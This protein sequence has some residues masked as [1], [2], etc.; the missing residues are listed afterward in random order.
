MIARLGDAMRLPLSAQNTLLTL[1]GFA[2][3]FSERAWDEA[4][5]APIRAA[6]AHTMKAH[7]PYPA[8]AL[9][10][11]WNI[12]QMNAPATQL[13][14]LMGLKEGDSLL[15]LLM[16]DMLPQMI[17]NWSEV[18]HHTALRLRTESSAQG[19]NAALDEV[20]AHLGKVPLAQAHRSDAVIPMILNTG[21][22]RL[23]MFAT[24]AQ[25]GTPEDVM[26]DAL[27]IELFFPS[28]D[29]SRVVLEQMAAS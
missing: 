6:I 23:S 2:A 28:D 13:Y 10:R 19:G 16:S 27:K 21:A 14:G 7:A 8:L 4:E 22:V 18:A 9:D 26:L 20:A 24:I 1:A 3:R 25:F 15:H 5:M 12:V 29:A 17:E 11:H